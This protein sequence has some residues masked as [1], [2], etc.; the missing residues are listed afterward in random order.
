MLIL[1]M[2]LVV[3]WI[4][5]CLVNELLCHS[6]VTVQYG[7]GSHT[8]WKVLDFFLE[9][10]GPGKSWKISLVLENPLNE[11]L[12]SWKVLENEDPV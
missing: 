3:V 7:H 5:S 10:T 6:F 2:S 4:H 1:Q 12:R 8:S 9:F 11:S